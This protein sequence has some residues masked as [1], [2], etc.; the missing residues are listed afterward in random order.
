MG[1]ARWSAWEIHC[2]LGGKHKRAQIRTENRQHDLWNKVKTCQNYQSK[3]N[4]ASCS[5]HQQNFRMVAKS[6]TSQNVRNNKTH[7]CHV[8]DHPLTPDH[9]WH[10]PPGGKKHSLH[11]QQVFLKAIPVEGM[12]WANL[13]QLS[14]SKKNIFPDS[15]RY[16]FCDLY[17]SSSDNMV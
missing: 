10:P 17:M 13:N 11:A 7:T 2:S 14:K 8:T 4:E 3:G 6:G 16:S 9:I 15:W 5:W 1:P 12:N